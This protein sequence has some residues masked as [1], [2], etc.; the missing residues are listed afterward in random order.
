[1]VGVSRL[2]ACTV[3]TRSSRQ[4]SISSAPVIAVCGAC[5]Q[6]ARNHRVAAF[7]A[8]HCFD[9]VAEEARVQVAEETDEAAIA[10]FVH[11]HVVDIRLGQAALRR[12]LGAGFIDRLEIPAIELDPAILPRQHGVWLRAGGHQDRP[13]PAA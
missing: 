5:G 7:G 11:Q 2:T 9:H 8:A 3:A 13:A 4:R 10:G 12:N 1:M 6:H